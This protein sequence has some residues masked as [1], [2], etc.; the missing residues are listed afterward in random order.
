MLADL[1][2]AL[3]FLRNFHARALTSVSGLSVDDPAIPEALRKV[4]ATFGDPTAA[5]SPIGGQ[6]S[7]KSP[8]ELRRDGDFV[9]FLDENQG[10]WTCAYRADGGADPAVFL[11]ADD[12]EPV[13]Q[14][15]SVGSF[16]VTYL[17]QESVMS[18]PH[19]ASQEE[20]SLPE[21]ALRS[22]VEPLWL[23]AVY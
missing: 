2:D 4:Y 15:N 7:L 12:T 13:K 17:L 22:A 3:R 20:G 21:D 23:A 18:A 5:S 19:F 8:S 9:H 6:D 14:S 11:F 16:L 10:C 1:D